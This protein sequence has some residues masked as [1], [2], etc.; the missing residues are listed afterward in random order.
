[1]HQ[2]FPVQALAGSA[3]ALRFQK[4]E[5]VDGRPLKRG[6]FEIL[7]W[8]GDTRAAVTAGDEIGTLAEVA[9]VFIAPLGPLVVGVG[10][11]QRAP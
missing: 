4:K 5:R 8:Q 6:F 3:I 9:P 2:G 7:C 11:F 1:M 10:R